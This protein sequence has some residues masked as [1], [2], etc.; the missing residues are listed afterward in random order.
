MR[1]ERVPEPMGMRRQPSQRARV[2]ASPAHRDEERPLRT[3]RQ[4]RARVLEVTGEPPTRLFAERDDAFLATLP[5]HVD[6]LL[7]E[8]DVVEVEADR[9]RATQAGGV[10]ELDEGAVA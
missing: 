6:E 9:L 1:G 7:L 4:L 8:V 10:D 2:Q 5:A 3:R